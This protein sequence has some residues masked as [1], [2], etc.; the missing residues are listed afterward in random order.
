MPGFARASGRRMKLGLILPTIGS[1]AGPESPGRRSG[2]R[3]PL[4]WS[5]VWTTDHLL[6]PAGPEADDTAGFSRRRARSPGSLLL[7]GLRAASACSSRRCATPRCGKAAR[8]DRLPHRRQAHSR[9][10][11]QRQHDLPEYENLGKADRF[12]RR[13][14][15]LDES[16]ALWRH[17]W[18]GSTEPFEG[19]F[20]TLRDFSFQPLPPQGASLPLCCGGRSDRALR[21]AAQL[22][23]GYHAAQTGPRTWGRGPRL[24]GRR[25]RQ[26]GRPRDLGSRPRAL[27]PGPLECTA[28]TASPI[29]M[30]P[31]SWPSPTRG[32]TSW[33][34][35]SPS[36]APSRWRAAM[37][38]FHPEVYG[39]R[40]TGSRRDERGCD[41]VGSRRV[42]RVLSEVEGPP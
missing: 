36:T 40:S 1:G 35:S 38:R 34:S 12:N 2:D 30:I 10:R 5:S 16:I 24:L 6:V 8:D 14:A 18:A 37:E 23:D 20:H 41:G 9:C 11:R 42:G 19:E 17:L 26:A 13:G 7:P 21:R 27:L 22:S 25:R 15:F 4:G 39:P 29:E 31:E 32:S 33:S 28:S 3:V